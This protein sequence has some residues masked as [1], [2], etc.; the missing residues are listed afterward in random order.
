MSQTATV[1]IAA[2]EQQTATLSVTPTDVDRDSA[3]DVRVRVSTVDAGGSDETAVTVPDTIPDDQWIVGADPDTDRV[4]FLDATSVSTTADELE[5]GATL[6]QAE[7]DR[8]ATLDDV[9]DVDRVATAFGAFRR[10]SMSDGGTVPIEPPPQFSPPFERRQVHPVAFDTEQV[11]PNRYQATLRLGLGRPRAR[12]PLAGGDARVV[13]SVTVTL[14]GGAAD[15][16]T[17]EWPANEVSPGDRIARVVPPSRQDSDEEL[18]SVTEADWGFTFAA[19][20][21]GLSSRQVGRLTRQS[22]PSGVEVTLPVRLNV[23]QAADI[24]AAGSRVAGVVERRVPDGQNRRRDTLPDDE[25]TASVSVPRGA[26][27]DGGTW[28]LIDWRLEWVRPGRLP[29]V[30]ELTFG[31]E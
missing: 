31:I 23:D 30:G 28:R 1:T 13:D 15:G 5:L 27:V 18:V 24:M 2:G 9:G 11:T 14:S 7:R 6:S 8:L 22:A 16:V 17:L 25:A 12:E 20:T 21:V 26:P 29:V 4:A 3:N 10:I 19:T